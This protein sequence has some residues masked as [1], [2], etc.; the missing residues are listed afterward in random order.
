MNGAAVL[1]RIMSR[2]HVDER[3][4]WVSSYAKTGNGYCSIKVDGRLLRVHRLTF[5]LLRSPIP[6]GLQL[7]HLCRRRDCCNPE[8]LEP[9][10]PR[11]NVLRGEG[12]CAVNARKTHCPRGHAYTPGNLAAYPPH[13]RACLTCKRDRERERQRRIRK[14]QPTAGM[15]RP[16]FIPAR[17]KENA[18][19]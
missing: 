6:E 16:A 13:G 12:V 18:S 5:E 15:R 9:V 17:Q 10:T 14:S 2:V 1:A 3:G 4:C 19:G 8:H 11:E 7:D